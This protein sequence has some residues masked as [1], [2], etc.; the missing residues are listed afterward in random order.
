MDLTDVEAVLLDMDG[1]LVDTDAAVERAWTSWSEEH[2]LEPARVLAI[3]HG[4]PGGVTV[5]RVLPHLDEAEAAAATARLQAIQHADLSGIVPGAGAPE[6]L[7]TLDRRGLPWAVVTSSDS[8]M[9][10]VTLDAVGIVP[11]LL[12]TLDDVTKGKPDPEGYLTAA[13]RLGVDPARCLVVEDSHP[14]VAAG[15]AAGAVVAA[16]KGVPADLRIDGLGQVATLL[17]G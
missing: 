7:A 16:L 14:G 6:L 9:A 10:K 12:L 15:K 1:T 5:R 3:A 13:A 8:R 4:S 17:G 2:G 11:P